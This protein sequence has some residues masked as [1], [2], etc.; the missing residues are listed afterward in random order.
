[1]T[2]QHVVRLLAELW[3][4]VRG[5]ESDLQYYLLPY[6][7]EGIHT[8]GQETGSGLGPLSRSRTKETKLSNIS[9]KKQS[10]DILF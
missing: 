8:A 1:M 5:Q 7:N 3:G 6:S 9:T 2:A 10:L 4:E